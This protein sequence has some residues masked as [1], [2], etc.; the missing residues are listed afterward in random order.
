[1]RFPAFIGIRSIRIWLVMLL[2]GAGLLTAGAT[3]AQAAEAVGVGKFVAGNCSKE[4]EKCGEASFGPYSLPKEPTLAEAK[5]QGYTQAAGHPAYG[6]THFE[7][8]TVGELPNLVPI[9]V[10]EG[11]VVTHVRT[12]V[13]PGVST[14]PEAVAKCSMNEFNGEKGELVP[15]SGFYLK[16]ECKGETEIGVNKV[17]VYA[18]PNGGGPGVSDIPLQ[19]KVYNLVQ[20]EGLASDFGVA[21]ELPKP[22]TG[23]ALKKGFEEAEAKGAKPEVED[24]PS[25]V[26]QAFLESLQYYSHTLIE[27]SVEWAGNY[28]DYYEI[29]VSPKLPLI[30]S[31]L[32]L[33]GN[34]GTEGKGGFITNPSNCAG[35]GPATTNTVTLRGT[36]GEESSKQYTTPIGTEGCNGSAPFAAVPFA[37]EFSLTPETIQSDQPDGITTELKLAHDPSPEGID[38]SQL[39][40]ASVTLPEGMTLN[41]SAAR[42]L[43]ACTPA[44]IGIGTRNPVGCPSGSKLGTVTLVV[45]DLPSNE[46][47]EGNLYLG[48][49]ESGPITGPPYTMYIDAESARYGVSVRLKGSV[50]PNETTGRVTATFADNPEQPFSDV[51]LHFNG[52][53]LALIANPLTCVTG[54]VEGIFTP[55]TG[56][57]AVLSSSPFTAGGCSSPLPFAPTQSTQN[58]SATA[59]ALTSFTFNLTRPEGQQ[60]LSQVRTVLPPGLLGP[61]PSVTLCGEAQANAGSCTAASQIGNVVASVGAGL[62]PYVFTNGSVYLTGPY[63]GAPYGLSIVVPAVAGPFNL[64]N[65]VTR[66]AINVDQHSGQL[67]V[68]STLPTIVGG[69]PLRL[70]SVTIAINRQNF[71]FNP[72][73]CGTLKT[74]S[75]VTGFT[76]GSNATVSQNLSTPFQVGECNKLAFKPSFSAS[77][78]ARTSKANG[79]SLEVKITQGAHQA[80]IQEVTTQLPKQLPSRLTTLQK[81]C[82]AATFEVADPPGRCAEGSRVGGA[83]VTTPVL[84]GTLSGPAYLVSHGGEAFPDLDLILRGDGVVVVLVGHTH[85]TKGITTTKFEALPDVPVSSF[86]LNLPIGSHSALTANGNLC[87]QKLTM[88]TTIVAQSGAKIT[89]KTNI[90]VVHCPVRIVGHRTS[91]T[92]AVIT[93]QAP[94]AG[95][96]SGSGPNLKF[97][98][99]HVKKAT[100]VTIYVPLTHNGEGI[101]DKFHQLTTRLRVGFIPKPGRPTSTAYVTVIFRS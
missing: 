15:G 98:A 58:Q 28:H 29:N 67:I 86:S 24:F 91:G 54:Q 90:S 65:V 94:E 97:T 18:G 83:T 33:R 95:R 22:L 63:N 73:N 87:T 3:A 55:Y 35:P 74:E 26:E 68:T 45:P 1:M 38:S 25:L 30:S 4:F 8:A 9:G 48:G 72:T 16:P 53:P 92:R 56:Q 44:Q 14:N 51:I 41:P 47:L 69:I 37:P 50:T 100:K 88:P 6:I 85:I 62:T 70:R 43:E 31:R 82:P 99:K 19:G 39:R 60:Y 21:L 42:G 17:I 34:I 57:P 27:G 93:V 81:A 52:G 36:H 79:A 89:Q 78:S 10:Q 11:K 64:G 76:P 13:G 77:T 32:V 23:A 61:I 71:L 40:N 75:T 20:P 66:A 84:P 59:G 5:E 96:V 49:P 2:A 80:N 12:D 46:P 7:V 101:L